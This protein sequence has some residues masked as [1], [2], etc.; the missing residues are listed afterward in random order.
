M[1]DPTDYLASYNLGCHYHTKIKDYKT[2]I[3]Y[4]LLSLKYDNSHGSTHFN[5]G[6]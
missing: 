4:Y 2:A 5:L 3:K 6:K 1:I